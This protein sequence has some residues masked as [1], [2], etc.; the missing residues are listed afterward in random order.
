MM[1]MPSSLFGNHLLTKRTPSLL[2]SPQM[3]QELLYFQIVHRFE[4]GAIFQ[5]Q[6]PHRV[7]RINL[8]FDFDVSFDRNTMGL[9]EINPLR[10]SI[11]VRDFSAKDSCPIANRREIL[12]PYPSA[13]FARVPSFSPGPQ[14]QKDGVVYF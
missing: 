12:V 4:G 9:E 8:S 1:I 5:V 14:C 7:V 13:R 6:F 11:W 2:S 10:L 3:Q